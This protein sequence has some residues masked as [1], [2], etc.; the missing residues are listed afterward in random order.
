MFALRL[1]GKPA[2]ITKRKRVWQQ[3]RKRASFESSQG[4]TSTPERKKLQGRRQQSEPGGQEGVETRATYWNARGSSAD[5]FCTVHFLYQG[6]A[7]RV[8][9]RRPKQ[10]AFLHPEDRLEALW[11]QRWQEASFPWGSLP[12]RHGFFSMV[13]LALA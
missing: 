13:S 1:P 2:S 12:W 7:A 3:C 10:K 9:F 4:H 6:L 8:I 5:F 11:I